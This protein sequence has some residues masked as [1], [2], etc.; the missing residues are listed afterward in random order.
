MLAGVIVRI[1]AEMLVPAA[2]LEVL[3]EVSEAGKLT[4]VLGTAGRLQFA[5]GTEIAAAEEVRSRDHGSPHR[6]IFVGALRPGQIVVNP[7]VETHKPQFTAGSKARSLPA[8][9]S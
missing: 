1:V 5:S 9:T 4:R 8:S 6:S 7:Q 2:A 3:V